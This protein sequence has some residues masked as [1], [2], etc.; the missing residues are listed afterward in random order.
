[1]RVLAVLAAVVLVEA[2][3][4]MALVEQETQAVEAAARQE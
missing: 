1:V 3:T 4:Q 2:V